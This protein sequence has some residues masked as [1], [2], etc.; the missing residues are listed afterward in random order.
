M[1][2]MW[3]SIKSSF[4]LFCM[5]WPLGESTTREKLPTVIWGPNKKP[6]NPH[7]ENGML[8][9]LDGPLTWGQFFAGTFGAVSRSHHFTMRRKQKLKPPVFPMRMCVLGLLPACTCES[10]A[11][12]T[13]YS[14]LHSEMAKANPNDQP[15]HPE[16]TGLMK[17]A[18][19]FLHSRKR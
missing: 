3:G 15:H 10:I 16:V 7:V 12:K 19:P 18:L 6:I 5:G 13:N 1:A 14:R 9:V 11:I 2:S 17:C 8:S 4:F